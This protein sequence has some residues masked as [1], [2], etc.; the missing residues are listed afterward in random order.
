MQKITNWFGNNAPKNQ[1]SK[2][3]ASKARHVK[4]VTV[5]DVIKQSHQDQIHALIAKETDKAAGSADWLKHYP[6]ALSKVMDAL[7]EAEV[8]EA[9]DTMKEWNKKGVPREMQRVSVF[10]L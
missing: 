4:D 6:A 8:E 1:G 9:E 3:T 5:R 2:D 10:A 7:T